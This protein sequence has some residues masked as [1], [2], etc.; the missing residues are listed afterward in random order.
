MNNKETFVKI[1]FSV[2]GVLIIALGAAI[3]NVGQVGV[4]T[5]T[6]SNIAIGSLFGLSLGTYQ[7]ILNLIFLFFIFIFGRKY[8]GLGTLITMVSI[9]FLIDYFTKLISHIV[10]FDLTLPFKILS[11]IF[12]TMFFTFG[13]AFYISADLGVAP[14][15]AITLVITDYSHIQYKYIRMAQDII[16]MISALIFGGPV[17]VGTVINAFFNGPLIDLWYKKIS[18]PLIRKITIKG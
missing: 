18:N 6:A 16:F 5:Y 13:V 11:L 4:D 14:Y 1:I 9:G 3:L 10:F 8:I 12:G 2:T 15:D 17:G 7:F